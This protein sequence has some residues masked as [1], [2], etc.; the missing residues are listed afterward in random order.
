MSRPAPT[1]II[2]QALSRFEEDDGSEPF[3]PS[4]QWLGARPGYYFSRGAAGQG[5]YLDHKQSHSDTAAATDQS[6][7]IMQ[8]SRPV[9]GD[10][11]LREAEEA[12]GDAGMEMLDLRGLK[13]LTL[14]LERKYNANLEARM[15][16]AEQPD[17]F[18]E[19]EAD[20]DEAVKAM[21]VVASAPDLYPEFVRSTSAIP[22]LL[23]LLNHENSD[24]AADA[25][26]VLSEL[27]DGDAVEDAEEEAAA[28]V[29]GLLD[30]DALSLLVHRL[31]AFNE[32]VPEEAAAVYNVLTIFENIIEVKP[33]VAEL[34]LEKTKLLKW[35]LARLR[36]RDVDA[37]KQYASEILAILVQQSDANKRKMGAAN[38]IDAVL[39]A[40]A[41]YRN[42]DPETT[43]EEELVANLFDVV[44]SCLLLPANKALFV[45]AEGVEL[46]L[47]ILKSKRAARTSALK[48]LDFATSSCP[49]ACDR[50]VDQQGLKTL[51]AIFMGKLKVK[52]TEDSAPGEEEERTVSV[53]SSLLQNIA[54]QSRRDRVAAKFVE[55]EFE[56]CDRL[57]EIYFRY[58]ARVEAEEAR[59]QVAEEELDEDDSLLARMDAGLY[60]LQ[61]CALV[62]GALWL[63]G[64]VGVRK[65][66]LKLLHQKG[67]TL[68]SLRSVLLEYRANLGVEG[69]EEERQSQVDRAT[70]ML[71]ALGHQEAVGEKP[72][73]DGKPAGDMIDP[74]AAEETTAAVAGK[75]V[76]FGEGTEPVQDG[77]QQAAVAAPPAAAAAEPPAPTEGGGARRREER[78]EER[79]HHDSSRRRASGSS[80]RHGGSKRDRRSR[81]RSLSPR[82]GSRKRDRR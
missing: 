40:I 28:L 41:P 2:H 65:R 71:L 59:L 5:Y 79:S 36:P 54:K 63:V 1:H 37:N 78:R 19:S 3:R 24:I 39:Q 17:K 38:G 16:Y 43:E 61:Q 82:R 26:E 66:V 81:S 18:M 7:D 58:E 25:V 80:D 11:L 27:T 23:A 51:F 29:E 62:I 34:V 46:L 42:R 30:N 72:A 10:E 14:A 44:A 32:S 47:L 67:R 74:A 12:A 21:L 68:A 48:C 22:T 49:P 77:Q 35:L 56:K 4:Q 57:M 9:D 70:R 13:R 20:L 6:A 55:N 53:I 69:G 52:K 50:V 45:E 31:N 33:E 73:G 15:K 64:D 75:A 76:Q 8:P 60:T